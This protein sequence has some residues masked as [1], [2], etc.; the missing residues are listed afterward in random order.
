M[1]NKIDGVEGGGLRIYRLVFLLFFF[2]GCG[3]SVGFLF[4]CFVFLGMGMFSLKR[5]VRWDFVRGGWEISRC[6]ILGFGMAAAWDIDAAER[7]EVVRSEKCIL[8]IVKDGG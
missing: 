5:K 2:F 6:F 7:R 3:G 4:V 8:M 1:S